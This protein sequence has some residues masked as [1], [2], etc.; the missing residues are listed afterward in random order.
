MQLHELGLPLRIPSESSV[1]GVLSRGQ[2]YDLRVREGK[3]VTVSLTQVHVI[4]P[5]RVPTPVPEDLVTTMLTVTRLA[6][7]GETWNHPDSDGATPEELDAGET[8]AHLHIPLRTG[9]VLARI[10][11]V[12]ARLRTELGMK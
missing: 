7:N 1:R 4:K 9:R 10:L 12:R 2:H 11:S 6:R 8:S 3:R 5:Q